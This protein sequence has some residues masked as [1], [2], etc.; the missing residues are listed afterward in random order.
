MS[1]PFLRPGPP[2][3]LRPRKP[4]R[5]GKPGPGPGQGVGRPLRILFACVGNAARSQMAQGFAKAMGG[6]RVEAR[7]GGSRPAGQVEPNATAVMAE[8]GIDISGHTSQ[9][10]DEAW[11]REQCDL[12]VTMGCGDD[13]CPAFVGKPLVDW[14]LE[15]PKGKPIGEFR[16]I[17]DDI[18]RRVRELLAERGIL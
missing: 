5:A 13:A 10:F 14:A 15:D 16:S 11:I 17:R 12:V 6:S 9:G 18:Q 2:V 1:D 4:S 3:G 8:K 7:S